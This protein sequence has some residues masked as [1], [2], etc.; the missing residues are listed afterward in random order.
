M[1]EFLENFQLSFN[2]HNVYSIYM[3]ITTYPAL[4]K[5]TFSELNKNFI[6][7]EIFYNFS[8][9]KFNTIRLLKDDNDKKTDDNRATKSYE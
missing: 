1:R 3:S 7:I 6:Y 9:T 5:A 8:H 2:Y 4:L